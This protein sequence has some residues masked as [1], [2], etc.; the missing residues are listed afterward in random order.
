MTVYILHM[1]MC[2]KKHLT[3]FFGMMQYSLGSTVIFWLGLPS[4]NSTLKPETLI[5]LTRDC[6]VNLRFFLWQLYPYSE[7]WIIVKTNDIWFSVEVRS[8]RN[9]IRCSQETIKN[10]ILKICKNE[11]S[12]F[13]DEMRWRDEMK[14]LILVTVDINSAVRASEKMT[15]SLL[16][17][18]MHIIY[19]W[20]S[21][22]L[23]D[24]V[25]F[26]SLC[27]YVILQNCF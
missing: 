23:Y 18:N 20:Q 7:Q 10:N 27:P 17:V 14:T 6:S 15:C 24:P 12:T 2:G 13:W 19:M 22:G 11:Q 9:E 26:V 1:I 8:P 3:D 16:Y 5:S 4:A 25:D 21:Q